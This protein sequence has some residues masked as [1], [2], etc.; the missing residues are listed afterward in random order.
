MQ[1]HLKKVNTKG[2]EEE[3]GFEVTWSEGGEKR[4]ALSQAETIITSV[5]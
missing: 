4:K 3:G 5:Q 2:M 1:L